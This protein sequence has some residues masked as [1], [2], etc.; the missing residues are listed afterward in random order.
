MAT[1]ASA[2]PPPRPADTSPDDPSADALA[3]R[4][5]ERWAADARYVA[6]WDE[7][8]VFDGAVWQ[9][10]VTLRVLAASRA[11]CRAAAEETDDPR[12]RAR[13][14]SVAAVAA[15]ERLARLDRRHLATAAQWDADPWLLNTP[16]GTV[17]LRTGALR[18]HKRED[19][20]TGT[21]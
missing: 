5:T 19:Y 16:G 13:L 17:D 11:T 4:F 9:P 20:L 3:R 2:P 15:V 21:T 7:W 10:D 8:M 6:A 1:V 12:A 18:P 14:G